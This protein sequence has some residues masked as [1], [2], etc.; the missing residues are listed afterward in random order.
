MSRLLATGLRAAL[1][2]PLGVYLTACGVQ[3]PSSGPEVVEPGTNRFITHLPGSSAPG[4][5][6]ADGALTGGDAAAGTG[7]TTSAAPPTANGDEDGGDVERI[8]SEAD[9]IKVDGTKLYALSRYSGL[10]VIDVADPTKLVL[11]GSHK[12]S[13]TPF[14]MYV[15]G[16]R[17]YVMYNGWGRYEVNDDGYWS[18]QTTSRI[19][20]LDLSNPAEIALLGEHDM[21][22]YLSDSRKVGDVLYLVTYEDGYCWDCDT[23]A[24]TRVASFNVQNPDAFQLIDELRL[25]E[26]SAYGGTPRSI[27]VTDERIY[28]SG[29]NWSDSYTGEIDVV[30]ITDPNGD[31]VAGAEVAIAGPVESRWQMDEFEGTLRVITQPGGW[32][33]GGSPVVQ[34]FRVNSASDI[35]P[36]ASLDVILPRSEDLRSVRFDGDRAYA[37]TF[38][39]TDPLFTFDLSDPEAPLQVGELEIPGWVYHMEPRGDRVYALGYDDASETGGALHVSLFDVSNL[40]QPTQLAR[41]NFGGQ[42]ASFAEDQDRIHKAFNIMPDL[43]LILVPFSGWDYVEAGDQCSGGEYLSGIQLVD[44]TEDTLALRGAAPQVGQ[45][46]RGFM[47]GETLFGVSDNAVQTFDISDRDAPAALGRLE[48]ARNVSTIRVMGS[49]MLRFGTDWWT[50]ETT[51]DMAMLDQVDQAEPMGDLDLSAYELDENGC[52]SY[53]QWD[54]QVLVEGAYAYVPRRTM[55]YGDDSQPNAYRQ[56]ITFFVVDLHDRENPTL[57]GTFE[58][59]TDDE[60]EYLSGIVKTDSAILVGHVDGNYYYDPAS[61]DVSK[62]TFTYDVISLADPA[63]P[64]VV[65]EI[66]MPE[67]VASGG[68]GYNFGGCMIDIGFGWW[69]GYYYGYFGNPLQ[70][71]VSGDMVAS[72][73]QV[74]L[75]DGTDRVRY[76]LDQIDV[77]DPAHPVL[78]PAV[79]IPGSL[80]AFDHEDGRVVTM[81]Y[82]LEEKAASSWETCQYGYFDSA[83]SVCRTYRRVVH[84]LEVDGNDATLLD[85]ATVDQA[86]SWANGIA[87]TGSRVFASYQS[88]SGNNYQTKLRSLAVKGDGQLDDLGVTDVSD[89]SWGNLVARG[90]RAFISA[91]GQLIVVDTS[92]TSNVEV[93]SHEMGGYYCNALEVADDTA[94]CALGEQGVQAFPL[95]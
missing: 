39:Q 84:T 36:L 3:D 14:E 73:H 94:Y 82:A 16:E 49:S 34:T 81:D 75:K 89:M 20:A 90:K 64:V 44:M 60:K 59:S 6:S 30:D 57:A 83:D 22:G 17:A 87:V 5:E 66:E 76:Y 7:G 51:L 11:L 47:V 19:Q 92:D 58:V 37:I 71:L 8:I 79:N 86:E 62:V 33:N 28:I 21:P 31:L 68:F 10:S 32:G 70:A 91:Q 13:A 50:G 4:A 27:A 46:R 69:G 1:F 67:S 80:L 78:L 72:Q 45:A 43:G 23:T 48:L 2:L 88:Y 74:P 38:E 56:T 63:A 65:S 95:D 9:I 52:Y 55:N 35:E 77:S 25:P 29:W 15:E 93:T 53:S 61:G 18:Y 54:N 42:W 26:D 40:A 41:V 24:N 12:T 85:S